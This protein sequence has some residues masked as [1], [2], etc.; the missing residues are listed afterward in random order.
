MT[1]SCEGTK[2][3]DKKV[4]WAIALGALFPDLPNFIFF[5]IY[6]VILGVPHE[7]LWG[8][9]YLNSPWNNVFNLSHSFW[10]LPLLL[11]ISYLFKKR[12]A[13]FLFLSM[14]IHSLMDFCVHADDAY[15]HFWPLSSWRFYSP[16]S[17]W[18]P[19]HYGV[20]V[21]AVEMF[22]AG[23]SGVILFKRTKGREWKK[24]LILV[25]AGELLLVLQGIYRIYTS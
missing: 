6:G 15:A 13:V 19:L 18:D 17:Y 21:S 9:M 8:D 4:L 23:I 2:K 16:I 25:V 11:V 12:I 22:L 10:L 24:V 7:V 14:L 3:K 20:Y 1:S 5:T